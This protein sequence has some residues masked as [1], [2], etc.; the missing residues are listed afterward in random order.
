MAG[1]AKLVL[2]AVLS[3]DL[4]ERYWK[5]PENLF[6]EPVWLNSTAGDVIEI[7]GVTETPGGI[8]ILGRLN[9]EPINVIIEARLEDES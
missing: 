6:D 1:Q 7:D 9:S 4:W 3:T 5:A 8:R 2:A